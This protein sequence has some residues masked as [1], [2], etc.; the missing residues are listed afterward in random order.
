MTRSTTLTW[1]R[2]IPVLALLAGTGL[3]LRSRGL[4][5]VLPPHQPLESFPIQIGKWHG[6]I[7]E[8]PDW[9]LKVLGS[10]EFAERNYLRGDNEPPVDLYM[11]YFPTQRMG[12]TMHSPQNCLPGSGW[13]PVENSPQP[14]AI[15][16]GKTMTVNRYILANGDR[17]LLVY[18]W[19][20]EH[21]RVIASE[22]WSKFYL[23]ADSIRFNRSDGAL[24]R[25]S[26]P[27]AFN[28]TITDAER[29]SKAFVTDLVPL[30]N[31]YIPK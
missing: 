25:V 22:Y 9:A 29:R 31:N 12:S 8:I 17:R 4:A 16:G 28:E 18:Y 7:V 23:V 21:G 19:F 14:L 26:T 5:E 20:Q 13:M 24:I 15:A 30:L 11:A 27:V 3:F 6:G 10:G 1:S 2:T